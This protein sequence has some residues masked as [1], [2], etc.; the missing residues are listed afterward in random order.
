MKVKRR[1]KV[2]GLEMRRGMQSKVLEVV[3]GLAKELQ[4]ITIIYLAD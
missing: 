3:M 1:E 2:P 4:H